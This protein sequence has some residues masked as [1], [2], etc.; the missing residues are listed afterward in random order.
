MKNFIA[1]LIAGTV[2]SILTGYTVFWHVAAKQIETEVRG[3]YEQLADNGYRVEGEFPTI[4][5]FPDKHRISFSGWIES[6]DFS[7]IIPSLKIYGFPIQRQTLTVTI[8][9]GVYLEGNSIDSDLYAIDHASVT[10]SLPKTLPHSITVES[11]RE[12]NFT[13]PR[14]D[15][16]H[17]SF[18]KNTLSAEGHGFLSLDDDLQPQGE[19][20]TNTEGHRAFL[21]FLQRKNVI[22]SKEAMIAGTVLNGLSQH[23]SETGEQYLQTI[24]VVRGRQILLGPLSIAEVPVIEWPYETPLSLIEYKKNGADPS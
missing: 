23:N 21:G 20:T 15:I 7:L 6:D 16:E 8:E 24:F 10:F 19:L 14:I 22:D 18:Q 2:F 17:F 5:G 3:L 1:I 4:T 11:L 13:N 9:D 12:W